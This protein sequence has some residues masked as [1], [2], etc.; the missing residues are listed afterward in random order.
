[1]TVQAPIFTE[2]F[3]ASPRWF[4]SLPTWIRASGAD[5]NG[6]L[7]LIEQVIPSGFASPWH[8]HHNE[9]ESFYVI[10]GRMTVVVGE[11]ALSLNTGDYA[12]GP[13]GIPHGFRIE[14]TKPTRVLLMTNGG[15]FAEFV[16]EASEPALDATPPAPSESDLPKLVAMAERYGL[17]ILGPM[18]DP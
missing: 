11:R 3:P 1:M 2:A 9:D 8:V 16:R 14:G 4:L 6:S 5:T 13:R 15:A 17:S 18:R 7:S 10:D 12:F